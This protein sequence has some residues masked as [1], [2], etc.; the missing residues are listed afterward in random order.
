MSRSPGFTF[1]KDFIGAAFPDG[2]DVQFTKIEASLLKY[3][4]RN[5]G[6]VITRG[7]LLAALNGDGADKNDRSIDF[8][9]NRLRHKLRDD[10]KTPNYIATR[11]GEGYIWLGEKQAAPHPA[12]GAHAV[13]G[14]CLGLQYLTSHAPKAEE[15]AHTFHSS[16]KA[17]FAD[18]LPVIFDPD[19]PKASE[20][21]SDQAPVIGIELSFVEDGGRLDCVFRG[22]FLKTERTFYVARRTICAD[23]GRDTPDLAAL[24]EL[25]MADIRKHLAVGGNEDKPLAVSM[26]DSGTTFSGVKGHWSEN[27]ESLRKI[28]ANA[29]DDHRSKIM[30]ATNIHTKYLQDGVSIFAS[31]ADPRRQDEDDIEEL[32]LQSLPHLN[33]DPSFLIVAAKLL[34]FVDRGYGEMAMDIALR[35][36]RET[37]SL[38]ASLPVI[39]QMYVFIGENEKGNAAIDQALEQCPTGTQ[40]EVYLLILKCEALAAVADY[41]GI[42]RVLA[43]V[44]AQVPQIE[45]LMEVLFTN[46]ENPSKAAQQELVGMS[47]KQAQGMLLYMHYVYGR[48]LQNP[49]HRQNAYRTSFT[50]FTRQFG[51]DI[52]PAEIEG[53]VC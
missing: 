21:G 38:L 24:I 5:P 27:D 10:P 1:A 49:Q 30:L 12:S 28:I 37:T 7:A 9:I 11:Y 46:P 43:R 45:T 6:Q 4:A 29:P 15:F 52:I 44:Y 23:G 8:V 33:D 18:N 2:T 48:L 39:G 19:S 35:A 41:D 3:M 16:F 22:A 42:D 51:K 34:F 53:F 17:D 13:V 40:L 31:G 20:Y 14:P 36:H 47:R 50:L 26:I 32:V 25:T